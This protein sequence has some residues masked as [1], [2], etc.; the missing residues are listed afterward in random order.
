MTN[1]WIPLAKLFGTKLID[2]GHGMWQVQDENGLYF[3]S[4]GRPFCRE[5]QR[6]CEIVTAPMI[7]DREYKLQQLMSLLSVMGH[8]LTESAT[9]VHFDALPLKSSNTTANLVCFFYAYGAIPRLLSGPTLIAG[10]W[11]GGRT[12]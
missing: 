12:L 6:P 9:H 3:S 10:V 8:D 7:D 1:H 5:R 4:H 2:S 11:V